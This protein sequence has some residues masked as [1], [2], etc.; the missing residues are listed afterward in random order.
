[1]KRI[2]LSLSLSFF[3][4]LGAFSQ[5]F[6]IQ[7]D[8]NSSSLPTSWTN[9]AISGTPVWSFGI[10]AAASDAGNN[11]LDGTPMVFFDDDAQGAA[12]LNNT[13]SLVTPSFNNSGIPITYLEFDYNLRTFNG[14]AD[15]FLVDVFDGTNWNRVLSVGSDQ[16]GRWTQPACQG[17]FPHAIID[18][19]AFASATSQVRFIYT[20][21]NDWGWYAGFDNVEIWSP[22][23][24]DAGV[25]NV[26]APQ[27]GCGLTTDTVVAVVKNL[28][29]NTISNFNVVFDV[30]S[31]SQTVTETISASIAPGD[32]VTHT[33]AAL[34]NL[35]TIGS[36]DI[37]VY[38]NLTGD[39]ATFNDT[40]SRTVINENI[41]TLT[42]T[43][44]FETSGHGWQTS[45]QNSSWQ[46]GVPN[47]A[48][49][50]VAASGQNAF[51]T[52]LNGSYNA[53]ERSFLTSP[54]MDFSA[55]T[56]DPI[57]GFSMNHLTETGFDRFWM[58]ASIDNGITWN[59]IPTHPTF[60]PTN[61]Y[62]NTAGA[63]WEGISGGWVNVENRL[64]GLAGQS[65]VKLRF[66]FF[67]DGSSQLEG[68]G[69]DKVTVRTPQPI[70]L[71]VNR[72]LYPVA[73]A[74][75]L[76]G[77]GS[78]NIIVEYENKGT[79][80]I[81]SIIFGY[82]VDGGQI[83]RDTV[84]GTN[85][86]PGQILTHQFSNKFNFS[87]IRN[88][89]L[90]AWAKTTGDTFSP[91]DTAANVT[92]TN[93]SSINSVPIPYRQDFD[94]FTPNGPMG[95]GWT[96]T[97]DFGTGFGH[98]WVVSGGGTPSF[99]TGPDADATGGNFV[100]VEASATGQDPV[101]ES[102]CINLSNNAGARLVFQYHKYGGTMGP[103]FVDVF[104]GIQWINSVDA[105]P[106]QTQT[107]GA[108]AWLTR[109][110]NLNQ[111]AGRRIKIRF[112]GRRG[113]S[114]TGDMA[115]DDVFIFEPLPRDI[116]M[117]DVLAPFAGC[118]INTSSDVTIELYNPGTLDTKPDSVHVY[119]QVDSLPP[120][121]DTVPFIIP[122]ENT[123]NFTFTV[124]A[125]FGI[126]G[127]TYNIKAWTDMLG[128]QND[129]NDTIYAYKVKNN[130]RTTNYAEDFES[131]RDALC[132]QP[133]GQ[134]ITQG[135]FAPATEFG[136]NVQESTCGKGSLVTPTGSTGPDGD[137]TTGRGK[138]LYTES[139]D[140]D[141]VGGINNNSAVLESPCIDLTNNTA[142]RLSFWYHKYGFQMGT[143]FLDVFSNGSWING[144]DQITGQTQTSA[145]AAWKVRH[146]DLDAYTGGL[147]QFRFRGLRGGDRSD[148]A[149]DDIF[150]YEPIG[151][152][153]GI[154]NVSSPSGD[155][156]TLGQD[157]VTLTVENFGLTPIAANSIQVSYSINDSPEVRDTIPGALAVGA[158]TTFTFPGTVDMSTP[159]NKEVVLR[160]RLLG[161]SLKL[162]DRYVQNVYNR[163]MGLPFSFE[164]FE[165]DG[166]DSWTRFPSN[167]YA[168]NRICGPSNCID[169][170]QPLPPPPIPPNGP[171]GDHTFATP[172]QNGDGCYWV[173]ESGF[174][175][176]VFPDARLNFPCGSVDFSNSQNN[177]I[178]LSFWYHRFGDP[179]NMGDLFIDVHNGSQWINGVAVIRGVQQGDDA[180]PWQEYQV[181]LDQFAGVSNGNIRFRA[182]FNGIGGNMAIDDVSL[183][184]RIPDDI[185]VTKFK[186][187]IDDCGLSNTERVRVEVQNTGINDILQLNM[188][189]QITFTP[190]DSAP[191]LLPPVCD[192]LVGI[193][194]SGLN[195][196]AKYT[197]EFPTRADMTRPGTYQF[198]I[199][200]R[201]ARDGYA[202][203]DTITSTVV[204]E[205]RPFPYC[206]DFSGWTFG[207]LG[208]D[209]KDGIY[210][211]FW[212][213]NQTAYTWKSWTDVPGAGPTAGHTRGLND[214]YILA[215]DPDGMPGQ[216]AQ[217]ESPC[218]DLT[219]TP[220]ANLEFWYK[221]PMD[222]HTMFIDIKMGDAPW[223]E[224]VDTLYG[225]AV[226]NWTKVNLVLADFVGDFVKVRFRSI[227][228][229]GFYAID[230]LCIIPPPPQQMELERI[231][232]PPMNFCQ[233]LADEVVTYRIQ[234]T[235]FNAIDSFRVVLAV[236]TVFPSFP[237]GNYFRDTMWFYKGV[238][239][240]NFQPGNKIDLKLD[241]FPINMVRQ[242]RYFIYGHVYLPNDPDTSDNYI[243]DY[244]ILHPV[245]FQLPYITDFESN[246]NPYNG[247]L[248]G[249]S[250]FYSFTIKSG[251]DVFGLTGPD[252]DHT[253]QNGTGKYFVT[254]AAAGDPGDVVVVQS[255]CLDLSQASNP[256]MSYWY[257]MFGF[258]MGDLYVQVNDDYGWETVDS[259]KGQD[260]V[261]NSAPWKNRLVDLSEW[262]GDFVRIRFLSFR[263]GGAASDMGLDD[264]AIYDQPPLDIAP[265]SL[266]KPTE[267]ITSC[268]LRNQ[269][270][271]VR[272]RN[273][274]ADS[275]DFTQ[276]TTNI[277]VYIEM[278]GL[279]WDT[280][281]RTVTTNDWVDDASGLNRPLPKDSA[282]CILMDG[283]FD[284]YHIDTTF[285][286]NVAV[287]MNADFINTNDSDSYDVFTREEGGNIAI[288]KNPNDTVCSGESVALTLENYF[289]RLSWQ[290]R[291]VNPYDTGFW[292]PG[293]FPN[294]RDVY[295]SNP[296]TLTYYR[297]WVCN[298]I[299]SN[300]DSV[301]AI[302]PYAIDTVR[303]S[304]C[305]GDTNN[306]IVNVTVPD[307]IEKL[308]IY[309]NDIREIFFRDG[310]VDSAAQ[311][312]VRMAQRQLVNDPSSTVAND[313]I[314]DND[315]NGFT[316]AP[317]SSAIRLKYV[318]R[319]SYEDVNGN[320]VLDTTFKDTLYMETF[321]LGCYS[322]YNIPL[323]ITIEPAPSYGNLFDI[324]ARDTL[325]TTF[326]DNKGE[327]LNGGSRTG[328]I[329]TYNW[330]IIKY[331]LDSTAVDTTYDTLQS[332][333]VDPWQL[334]KNHFYTYQVEVNTPNGCGNGT[335]SPLITRVIDDKCFVGLEERNLAD[336]M[337]IYPNP[338]SEMLFIRYRTQDDLDGNITIRDING[339][340][341]V[342]MKNVRLN[343]NIQKIDMST[344]PKG[345]YFLQIDTDRGRVIE[346]II[347]S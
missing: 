310:V 176:G 182:Q 38:T 91:N 30:N 338:T 8:F 128:D 322:L 169:G 227:N 156:C 34:A 100:F 90:S 55:S 137:H 269:T 242:I 86:L 259:L 298:N 130:V 187:P 221:A 272:L 87:A 236:D 58:E 205:T 167:N 101:L 306:L 319:F 136:W 345:V 188:C 228:A 125:D 274:G 288:I 304:K 69:I 94:A 17:N 247:W 22:L 114:F 203:N 66:A 75:P 56:S 256:E 149:I 151:Q 89:T 277:V 77:F 276:D 78:E 104:D 118:E 70:D 172:R 140:I 47:N 180:D 46:R 178:L 139:I 341:I 53:S 150:L 72:V 261:R 14:I 294:N 57:L 265:D 13:V 233:Y 98:Q 337:S 163:N 121:K 50:N 257:H 229:G 1:M 347:K 295:V 10:D 280:L 206:E 16:C 190:L 168:W 32:S 331:T 122:S 234:N 185:A 193:L 127:K 239:F 315:V 183:L 273:N 31:G 174:K 173:I 179:Q 211:S 164:D 142:A 175:T 271:E 80:S 335:K 224:A 21:G 146:V 244:E 328:F 300:V 103:L 109:E 170:C 35:S 152:D 278:E 285:T 308:F 255:Q 44:D 309:K 252:D 54:C 305:A 18:I 312:A 33:F 113:T 346:K 63:Y 107:S 342:D 96:R 141:G 240:N 12:N 6:Y 145:S 61:W 48:S 192:S 129:L 166:T 249:A 62:N 204:N 196:G 111:Y 161:D 279:P 213:A 4:V 153:V 124:Q 11:N 92:V 270:V 330:E 27:S 64:N 241:S 184:D 60:N 24:T 162:N 45:G 290:E 296:D 154:N 215:F 260:Q 217:I 334:D 275:I 191:I 119:Y 102:P 117:K 263:G 318:N 223:T 115:V 59:K 226:F 132:D 160:T 251:V 281:Y 110:V 40:A 343:E 126:P 5:N 20:D 7:E 39:A 201:Q 177:R 326:D 43:E 19:S 9:S 321:R 323:I 219:N 135:W 344:L 208:K 23:P 200:A 232:V 324:P 155:G 112:R 158:T 235:G 36:Y 68:V 316:P 26:L 131:F 41:Y 157:Q 231:T 284:M 197:Y 37:K 51:V 93:G 220:T 79:S 327:I 209:F 212:T 245:P 95:Q 267:D 186:R 85:V 301:V 83:F 84:T 67:S 238:H 250:G 99:N 218:Y 65:Q 339:R 303:A 258:Q 144:V 28:G 216:I 134:V 2:L 264:I 106:G 3:F 138:F 317:A 289:G 291:T 171:S 76:C 287:N 292:L 105:I 199:W 148:M 230:D 88:Y 108:D 297:V 81:T 133:L 282:V 71:S 311:E 313:M 15:S 74:S 29:Y 123:A 194:I 52:D 82:R 336:K 253:R 329:Y 202:F 325:C 222:N 198:K 189:Y 293:T 286:F 237:R 159:G 307:N 248:T 207:W 195:R 97:P 210:P 268:Y 340:V 42:Y 181:G 314:L 116:E 333:T 243:D 320:P 143:L 299:Y 214:L 262:A 49:I 332:V 165:R 283:T 266:C 302:R 147:V 73:S 254:Q 120:V 225:N 246:A 25:S